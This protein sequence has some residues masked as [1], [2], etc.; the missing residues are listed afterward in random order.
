MLASLKPVEEIKEE[1]EKKDKRR[2]LTF[3]IFLAISTVLWFLIKLTKTYSTQTAF[4]INY[5]EIPAN[6]WVSTPEQQ[7]KL[8]FE[9]DG[10]VTLG[11]NLVR[12][13]R[14]VVEIPLNE[15]PY[16]L[17]GGVTYS[18]SSQYVAER[19]AGWLNIPASNITIND[20]K[21]YFNMEDLQ[22]KTLPVQVPLEVKTQRQYRI[23]GEPVTTPASIT[24]YGP[25]NMLDTLTTIYTEPLVA[26]NASEALRRTLTVNLYD[27][28]I[29]S[30]TTTVEAVVDVEKYTEQEVEVPVTLTDS[31]T[32]RFFPETM[33]VRC[34]VAIK[35]FG[36]L[37]PSS[38]LV[39]A[40]TAQL[41]RREPLLDISLAGVPD[42]VVVMSAKPSQVEYLII[43]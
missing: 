38:F 35:D 11:H 4:I 32:V 2:F 33:K 19:V 36:A 24:V 7:V 17:E 43:N 27:G 40:D 26:E 30:E 3:L 41:H 20:D 6:K 22:S 21:Q 37:K 5:T 1:I 25:K 16:R 39:L 15:V 42:H 18:Y 34:M 31:L 13:K 8:T 9:A 10:F 29:H 14:R 28:T 12:D 23:Y